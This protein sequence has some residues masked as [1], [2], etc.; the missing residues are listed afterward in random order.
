M[1]GKAKIWNDYNDPVSI[2]GIIS[3]EPFTKTNRI[4]M[5]HKILI[6]YPKA[7][8]V[9]IDDNTPSTPME[10]AK[11]FMKTKIKL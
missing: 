8:F 5:R 11:F 10:L 2:G 9:V 4:L 7:Q 6:K 1:T 3:K